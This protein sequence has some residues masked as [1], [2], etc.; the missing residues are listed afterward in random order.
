MII[1]GMSMYEF[2]VPDNVTGDPVANATVLITKL[3]MVANTDAD[4]YYLFD[5]VPAGT[6]TLSCHAPDYK[7]P[8][9]V[10]GTIIDTMPQDVNF[11]LEPEAGTQA[12]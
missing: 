9:N 2:S 4:G 3:G 7:L 6:F 12:A 5:E 8:A 10:A 11:G 1:S